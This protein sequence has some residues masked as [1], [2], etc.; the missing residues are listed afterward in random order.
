M[1]ERITDLILGNISFVIFIAFLLFG[2]ISRGDKKDAKRDTAESRPT[3]NP[4]EPDG[5]PLAER[6][7]E[8]F[9]IDLHEGEKP[10]PEKKAKPQS[11]Y[12]SDGRRSP[13][14]SS[15]QEQY[16]DLFGGGSLFARDDSD[17]GAN[18]KW[19]FDETEWGSTFVKNDEQWGNSF[20]EKKSSEP[21]VEWP[22]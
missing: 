14:Q 18:A 12:A 6:M 1:I 15:V 21:V 7:A 2:L 11:T 4:A 10:V 22:R 16:G 3:Q 9:G 20:P 13:N 8:Y 17:S 5:R 19:G